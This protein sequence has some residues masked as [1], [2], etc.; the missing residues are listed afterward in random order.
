MKKLLQC[1]IVLIA[2]SALCTPL[3]AQ[4][5]ITL[6][7]GRTIECRITD[8]STT[9]HSV[10]YITPDGDTLYITL[11]KVLYYYKAEEDR[12]YVK[13]SSLEWEPLKDPG[14][15]HPPKYRHRINLAFECGVSFPDRVVDTP[16]IN[17]VR[18]EYTYYFSNNFGAGL[19]V[20]WLSRGLNKKSAV[21]DQ[22]TTFTGFTLSYRFFL[23][24]INSYIVVGKSLP[25][26]I[27]V[28][29]RLDGQESYR[30]FVW[31]KTIS[32]SFFG[33]SIVP[34]L[35]YDL[36][37]GMEHLLRKNGKTAI[38]WALRISSNSI[39]SVSAGITFGA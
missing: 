20:N 16:S 30:G 33:S 6:K 27:D 38:N 29:T 36:N 4:D 2:F 10:F 11:D 7:S 9:D 26:Y 24:N 18:G 19:F 21:K 31:S 32:E 12:Y 17:S 8:T 37:F 39:F 14:M 22:N 28:T 5:K 1:L 34:Y 25:I 23:N 15:L 3:R 13:N 35:L